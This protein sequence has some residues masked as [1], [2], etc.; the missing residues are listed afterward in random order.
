MPRLYRDA[1]SQSLRTPRASVVPHRHPT[2]SNLAPRLD[3][4]DSNTTRCLL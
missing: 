1:R 4:E 2:V 3:G